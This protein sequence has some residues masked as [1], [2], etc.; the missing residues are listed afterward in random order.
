ML[1]TSTRGFRAVRHKV[2]PMKENHLCVLHTWPQM[3]LS[4]PFSLRTPC[5]HTVFFSQQATCPVVSL[6]DRVRLHMDGKL[7]SGTLLP[8]TRDTAPL[9]FIVGSNQV[10]PGVEKA[11]QGMKKGEFKTIALGPAEAFGAKKQLLTVPLQE[12]HLPEKER[13]K[14]AI[15]QTLELAG[16]ER[17]RIVLLSDETIE[18]DLAHPY[19]G[20]SLQAT[21]ELVDHELYSELHESERLVLPHVVHEGDTVTFPRR[22]D[23]VVVHYSG[24]L[25]KDNHEFDSS[26]NRGE[27]FRFQIGVGQV[28]CGWD[29]GVM[30]MSKG[31][32]ATLNIPAEKGYGKTGAGTVIPPNADL[33]FEV[34]LLDIVGRKN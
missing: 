14:L 13:Q 30:R 15:G 4:N 26:R 25:A 20:H 8:S 3:L 22:G 33:V 16:G 7:S 5:T 19:A 21:L 28:I 18:I 12:L 10:L 9:K 27:P 2:R 17:A 11:V 32:I 24:K 23:T 31:M 29:E 1:L 34:E 6:G